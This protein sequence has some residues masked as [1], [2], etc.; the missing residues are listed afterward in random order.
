[1]SVK[2]TPQQISAA[3]SALKTHVEKP[4]VKHQW[5]EIVYYLSQGNDPKLREKM[6]LELDDIMCKDPGFSISRF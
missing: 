2:Y 4:F 5:E 3:V 6:N 1:M